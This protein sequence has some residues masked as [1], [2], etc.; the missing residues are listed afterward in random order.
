MYLMCHVTSHDNLAYGSCKFVG[1][2]S[3]DYNHCDSGDIMFLI[4]HVTSGEHMFNRLY[5]F[6]GGNTSW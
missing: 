5:E 4:G 2:K 1:G 6:M 3:C